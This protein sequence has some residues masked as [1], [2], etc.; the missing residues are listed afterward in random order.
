MNGRTLEGI[1]HGA[2][3]GRQLAPIGH[4][5]CG[6]WET[7]C[8]TAPRPC[9]HT[10][11]THPSTSS[12]SGTWP[13]QMLPE[14]ISAASIE[15]AAAGAFQRSGM[16]TF[17]APLRSCTIPPSD[18]GL[19]TVL[20]STTTSVASATNASPRPLPTASVT[21]AATA[22]VPQPST[23][24]GASLVPMGE[25][26]LTR[27]RPTTHRTRLEEQLERLL[28]AA[29]CECVGVCGEVR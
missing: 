8:Q 21:S 22:T 24:G 11:C 9:H 1:T 23:G 25:S 14:A 12:A 26:R 18:L 15:A 19:S 27:S 29:V 7:R 2:R 17:S 28:V 16:D 10:A 6:A 13:Q 5:H 3:P 20:L 4:G